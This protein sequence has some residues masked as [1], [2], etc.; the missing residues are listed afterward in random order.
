MYVNNRS[1]DR[2]LNSKTQIKD[3]RNNNSVFSYFTWVRYN[4][5]PFIQDTHCF[6]N[7][8]SFFSFGPTDNFLFVQ[9]YERIVL[10]EEDFYNLTFP[11]LFPRSISLLSYFPG[12]CG[13]S[14]HCSHRQIFSHLNS[15][16]SHFSFDIKKRTHFYTNYRM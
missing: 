10:N 14:Q 15:I 12:S 2:C 4:F 7:V 16:L 5:L 11:S 1:E 9:F 3:F 13:P 6:F 8:R